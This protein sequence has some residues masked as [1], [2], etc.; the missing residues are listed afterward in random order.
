MTGLK[1]IRVSL[2]PTT[3]RR[4]PPTIFPSKLEG[5]ARRAPVLVCSCGSKFCQM[6]ACRESR[7][8]EVNPT[9]QA[10]NFLV[11]GVIEPSCHGATN[12]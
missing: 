1:L 8:P 5:S 7:A 3:V 11:L 12:R 10:P 6:M 9:S 4:L 2:A